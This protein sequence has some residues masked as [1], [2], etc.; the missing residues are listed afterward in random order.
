LLPLDN[1]AWGKREEAEEKCPLKPR[2]LREETRAE[3]VL[4][5]YVCGSAT[6]TSPRSKI[7]V[8]LANC[9]L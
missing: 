2:F 6:I 5:E 7:L 8:N 4:T 1:H 3:C 9:I